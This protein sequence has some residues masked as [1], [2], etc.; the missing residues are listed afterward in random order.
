MT[1]RKPRP[2]SK[3]EILAAAVTLAHDKGLRKFSRADVAKRSKMAS[4]TVSYHFG[5]MHALRRE[6]VK[7]AIEKEMV[8]ILADARTDRDSAELYTRMTN[9]LKQKVAAYIAR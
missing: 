8:A 4:A 7:L 5:D 9:E 6:V 2:S 1:T 3:P